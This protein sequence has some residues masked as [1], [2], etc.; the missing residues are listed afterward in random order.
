[1]ERQLNVVTRERPLL[2]CASVSWSTLLYRALW[3][4]QLHQCELWSNVFCLDWT[5]FLPDKV[6]IRSEVKSPAHS[7]EAL[8]CSNSYDK[9]CPL[10]II[11]PWGLLA[12]YVYRTQVE[13]TIFSLNASPFVATK[14][15]CNS[16]Y[17]LKYFQQYWNICNTAWNIS[18]S[19]ANGRQI[20]TW[21]GV[22]SAKNR[23]TI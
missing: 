7:G 3:P 15:S 9:I 20:S 21:V 11:F 14:V 17:Y 8:W 23:Q 10:L 16:T 13:S 6:F 22:I 19:V 18:S 12:Y 4:A 5:Q 2:H 1:M